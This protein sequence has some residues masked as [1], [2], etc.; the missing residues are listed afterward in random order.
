MN[1]QTQGD[2]DSG[3]GEEQAQGS[4]LPLEFPL[5]AGGEPWEIMKRNLF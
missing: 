5:A 3:W 1:G 4:H 2:G